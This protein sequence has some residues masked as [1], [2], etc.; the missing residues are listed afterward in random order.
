MAALKRNLPRI[1]VVAASAPPYGAGGVASAHYNL[2]RALRQQGYPAELFTFY[3]NGVAARREEGMVRHGAAPQWVKRLF[4]LL[5]LPWRLLQPRKLAYHTA[6]ILRNAPGA[7]RMA[8]SIRQFDPQIVLLSDHGAPGLWLRKHRGQRFVLVA[9][10]NPARLA[11]ESGLGDFSAADVRLAIAL[12]QRVLKQVDAVI[13]PSHYMRRWFQKTYHFGG[14]VHVIPNL[15]DLSTVDAIPARAIKPR[16]KLPARAQVVYLPSAGSRIKGGE[17]L[18]SILD[19]LLA[20]AQRPLG[21]YI[22]GEVD[23][24]ILAA[25]QAHPAATQILLA[26]QLSYAQH[27]GYVKSCAV[28]ISPALM[29]NFSMAIVE[30]ASVGV[31]VMAFRRGGNADIIADGQNGQL[32]PGLQAKALAA[33]ALEWLH[34]PDLAQRKRR[35]QAYT[36]QHF[37]QAQVLPAYLSVLLGAQSAHA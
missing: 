21:F 22:P 12:E 1:A 33:R 17:Y 35:A 8:R 34:A 4:V 19:A 6:E 31:P 23:A 30:A 37:S 7:L 36:R 13:C 9:H 18:L 16:L 5:N 10:H 29:E 3:D 14:P 28:A 20:Q 32:V 27:M 15:I 24:H 25:L 2:W 11:A 26:G